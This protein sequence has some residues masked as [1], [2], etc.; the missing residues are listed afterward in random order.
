MKHRACHRQDY[1]HVVLNGILIWFVGWASLLV[2]ALCPAYSCKFSFYEF[3]S[4][5][6]NGFMRFAISL[7]VVALKGVNGLSPRFCREDKDEASVRQGRVRR[8]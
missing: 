1:F 4:I 5:G 7:Y 2:D 6:M 3:L 8:H